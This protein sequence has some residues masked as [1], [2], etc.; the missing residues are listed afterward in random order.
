MG[1]NWS[2]W[3][4]SAAAGGSW[5]GRRACGCSWR[6]ALPLVAAVLWSLFAAPRAVVP[7][8]AGRLAVQV[9][10]FGTAA[11]LLAWAA[12]P[13]WGAAFAVVVAVNLVAAAALPPVG[14]P[15]RLTST[16]TEHRAWLSPATV[17]HGSSMDGAPFGLAPRIRAAHAR[18]VGPHTAGMAPDLTCEYDAGREKP[19]AYGVSLGRG[20]LSPRLLGARPVPRRPSGALGH[21]GGVGAD[22]LGLRRRRS[23]RLTASPGP[24]NGGPIGRPERSWLSRLRDMADSLRDELRT[25]AA[26][27]R[28]SELDPRA[29][30]LAPG[31]KERTREVMLAEGRAA[32][33]AAGAAVRRGRRPAAAGGCCSCCRAWT[34][35]ARAVWSRTS[36]G[37]VEP[38]GRAA[39][40]VQGAHAGGAAALLP[41]AGPPA[42]ARRPG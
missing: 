7:S 21:H 9:L 16:S 29:T 36:S 11:G 12:T 18:L 8:T 22:G 14:A 32:G 37:V 35:A 17:D 33:R 19:A 28:L 4:C 39:H 41:V 26:P 24:A 38:A 13:R 25:P 6:S 30:P 42:A 23:S 31:S 2:P 34:P 1:S 3:R 27:V 20:A 40:R 10:V 15:H 5:A